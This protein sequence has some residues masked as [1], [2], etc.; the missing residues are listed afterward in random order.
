VNAFGGPQQPDNAVVIHLHGG[1][2]PPD[3]DGFAELWFGNQATASAYAPPPPTFVG[4]AWQNIDPVFQ[5]PA[6][7]AI[8]NPDPASLIWNGNST[9]TGDPNV[10]NTVLGNLVR[11][12]G[13]SMIYN[14]PMVQDGATIWYHDHALG[15]TR[16]NVAAGPAGYF[17]INDPAVDV[18]LFGASPGTA[19]YAFGDCSNN[20]ILSG[21]CFDVPVVLQDRAFNYDGSIN[22][23]NGLGQIA[24]AGV[25][26][27]NPLFPGPNPLTH[28]QWVPEY[29]GDV[30]VVNGVIWP[31][32]TVEPR[33][34]RIRFLGGSNAR[35]WTL[36]MKSKNGQKP[37]FNIIASDQGYLPLPAA[38]GSFSICPGE[39]F[40]AVIDFGRYAGQTITLT[41]TAAAPFPNGISPTARNSP[42][43]QLA[44][45]MTFNVK[46][47]PVG[48]PAPAPWAPSPQW[49][50]TM[51][52]PLLAPGLARYNK[53]AAGT[54]PF[55]D[56]SLAPPCQERTQQVYFLNEVLDPITLAP[57]RVQIDGKAFEDPVTEIPRRGTYQVWNIVNTTVDAHPMHLHLVQF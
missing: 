21:A 23:P 2:M 12:T 13:D 54:V 34:Y 24:P 27:W 45:V 56:V 31:K 1:E 15:K 25:V 28:P 50:G 32:L 42:F 38:L 16:I 5:A 35:C 33:A 7:N 53:L 39:R 9:P 4:E 29:F 22:Y 48:T 11:P 36:G 6:G 10:A 20:G 49:A 19:G 30:A 44:N 55:C 57:L 17:Y 51:A 14:Y 47:L 41:N 43:A 26:G 18:P 37:P 46:P 3:S 52:D 8:L 40:E